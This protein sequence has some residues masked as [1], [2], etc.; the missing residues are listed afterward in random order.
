MQ[1]KRRGLIALW[2]ACV[3]LLMTQPIMVGADSGS[4]IE[5]KLYQGTEV[6]KPGSTSTMWESKNLQPGMTLDASQTELAALYGADL[7]DNCPDGYTRDG[8]RIWTDSS[9]LAASRWISDTDTDWADYMTGCFDYN[10]STILA[11]NWVPE[12][13]VEK[14]NDGSAAVIKKTED[15]SILV[16]GDTVPDGSVGADGSVTADGTTFHFQW[17]RE[18]KIVPTPTKENEIK[19]SVLE[20]GDYYDESTGKWIKGGGQSQK[21]GIECEL[22][23][24]DVVVVKDLNS[25]SSAWQYYFSGYIWNENNDNSFLRT[26][27][28]TDD[29]ENSVFYATVPSSGKNFQLWLENVNNYMEVN[30]SIS[31]FRADSTVADQTGAVYTGAAGNYCCQ[32]SYEKDVDG[33]TEKKTFSLL[34]NS[35]TVSEEQEEYEITKVCG[36]NGSCSIEVDG[37]E[38][39]GEP[40]KAAAGQTVTIKAVPANGYEEG[41]ISVKKTGVAT[42][43]ELSLSTTED[44]EGNKIRTFTMP[45]YPVTVSINFKQKAVTDT[46]TTAPVVSGIEDGKEYYGAVTFKVEDNIALEAVWVDGNQVALSQEST[47][48]IQPD[49]RSHTI[50]AKDVAGNMV[51]CTITVYETWVRDG[52][53]I[54]GDYMLKAGTPYKLG[55][56]TWKITDDD[57][58]YAGGNTFYVPITKSY[59][60]RKQ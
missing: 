34:A 44:E 55:A 46:D 25:D 12:Y 51:S 37:E 60:F 42:A 14:N 24:G 48:T 29:K 6:L 57:T 9:G 49:N 20:E 45:D 32:V 17:L 10:S 53:T 2:M 36:G 15:G 43:P 22:Q 30:A 33:G 4:E 31:V 7:K 3:L 21:M 59:E 27:F 58:V 35:A 26:F 28:V 23:P 13:S 39:T 11:P 52:I 54:N 19:G 1:R 41:T 5:V 47:Y 16:N 56:G 18:Y 40:I 8:W 38:I 50:V